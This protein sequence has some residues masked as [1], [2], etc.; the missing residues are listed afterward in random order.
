M[1]TLKA[2]RERFHVS[3]T[4]TWPA[5]PGS[6][7][8]EVGSSGWKST[9]ASRGVGAFRR[10]LKIRRTSALRAGRTHNASGLQGEQP[11][12]DGTIA[13]NVKVKK[14]NQRSSGGS[15]YDSLKIKTSLGESIERRTLSGGEFGWG[16]T[17]VKDSRVSKMSSARTEISCGTKAR[18]VRKVTTG[19]TGLWQPSVHSGVAFD[20]DV[21]SSYHCEAEFTKCWIVHP[22]IGSVSWV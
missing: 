16:G 12:V 17:S 11:A 6:G 10:P 8:A 18:G 3:G 5:H 1:R 13:L 4:C 21:G 19:I 7:S 20:P 2:K 9:A 22:P 15:N 14:F